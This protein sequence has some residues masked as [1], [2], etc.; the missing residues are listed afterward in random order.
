[1]RCAVIVPAYNE[2]ER[3]AR[4][5][6]A[7]VECTLASEVILVSDGS[8][9]A[10]AE[11]ART[12]PG[13]RCIELT[14]NQ[15]KGAAMLAGAQATTAEI[16]AFIDAD[17]E[18][19]HPTDVDRLLDPVREGLADMAVGVCCGG[20]PLSEAAQRLTPGISGQRALRR[21]A[22]LAVPGL[23]AS[24][25]GAEIAIERAMRKAGARIHLIALHGVGNTVKERKMGLIKGAAARAR[26]YAEIGTTLLRGG[27]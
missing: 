17:L 26:M 20:E 25:L 14:T 24:R 15:G 4:V 3:V 8:T 19:L 23:A 7:A 2:A 10:T 11:I 22:L 9:D 21:E 1:M 27:N 6:R 16:L 18:G 12:V 13:V 5:L